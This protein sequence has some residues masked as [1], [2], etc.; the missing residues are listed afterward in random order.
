MFCGWNDRNGL[1]VGMENRHTKGCSE[2]F[3]SF[4]LQVIN[5]FGKAGMATHPQP[6]AALYPMG[7]TFLVVGVCRVCFAFY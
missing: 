2:S 5:V 3:V 7:R 6:A 4:V 1:F